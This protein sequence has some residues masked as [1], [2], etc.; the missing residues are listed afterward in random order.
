MGCPSSAATGQVVRVSGTCF[1][2]F[3]LSG[4]LKVAFDSCMGKLSVSPERRAGRITAFRPQSSGACSDLEYILPEESFVVDSVLLTGSIIL[5]TNQNPDHLPLVHH[6][7]ADDAKRFQFTL[8][9]KRSD[10]TSD[11]RIRS[12]AVQA[13]TPK[14]QPRTLLRD[15]SRSS[16]HRSRPDETER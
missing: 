10:R 13:S 8:R 9:R 11:E 1:V 12:L 5:M 4:C 2:G 3:E 16:T 6:V 7:E 14:I 15:V